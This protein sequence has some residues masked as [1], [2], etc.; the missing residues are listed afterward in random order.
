[1]GSIF[2]PESASYVINL[3]S[4]VQ[5]MLTVC[6]LALNGGVAMNRHLTAET[7]NAVEITLSS[8]ET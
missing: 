4:A 8:S 2:T 6:N 5:N 1:M 3:K 7:K